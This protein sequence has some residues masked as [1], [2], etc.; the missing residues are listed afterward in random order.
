MKIKEKVLKEVLDYF[1][2][3]IDFNEVPEK[4]I[5]LTLAEVGKELKDLKDKIWHIKEISIPYIIDEGVDYQELNSNRLQN[6]HNKLQE[7][8]DE[9]EKPKQK[10]GI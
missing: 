1:P 5:D 9:F 2:Q 3:F 4:A 8:F 7:L 10:L 6:V